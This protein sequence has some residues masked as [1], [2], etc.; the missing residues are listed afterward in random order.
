[1]CVSSSVMPKYSFSQPCFVARLVFLSL[2]CL[3]VPDMVDS[4]KFYG[5]AFVIYEFRYWHL[6][7]QDSQVM[8]SA[9]PLKMGCRVCTWIGFPTIQIDI[10]CLSSSGQVTE[11][12]NN[13]LLSDLTICAPCFLQFPATQRISVEHSKIGILQLCC[14]VWSWLWVDS[15]NTCME[16]TPAGDVHCSVLNN[17]G[18]AIQGSTYQI[19]FY[20]LY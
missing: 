3:W 2:Y 14:A 18:K 12:K 4:E 1:M 20:C 15:T 10:K 9:R 11:N 6:P 5:G 19:L 13:L 7:E 8:S 17:G 16:Y